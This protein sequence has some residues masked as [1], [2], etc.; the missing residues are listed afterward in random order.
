MK[1]ILPCPKCDQFFL[2]PASISPGVTLKCP[3]CGFHLAADSLFIDI[4][5]QAAYW[6][7]ADS[8]SIDDVVLAAAD[9]GLVKSSEDNLDGVVAEDTFSAIDEDH[10]FATSGLIFEEALSTESQPEESVGTI[11]IEVPPS[12]EWETQPSSLDGQEASTEVMTDNGESEF[13]A[14]EFGF[15]SQ[16][17]DD[18]TFVDGS[19]ALESSSLDSA[20]QE[21]KDGI[22]YSED[23]VLII[24]DGSVLIEETIPDE[25]DV[26]FQEDSLVKS[27]QLDDSPLTLAPLPSSSA[28]TSTKRINDPF[29]SI[30]KAPKKRPQES[31][32]K[33][34]GSVVGGGVA[35]VP[36]A[37]L[38]MWYVLGKDPL[39]AGPAVAQFVPW[40]VP[41][42]FSDASGMRARIAKSDARLDGRTPSLPSVQMNSNHDVA[43]KVDAESE[44]VEPQAS[45]P[46]SS[47][48][49]IS[50]TVAA[51]PA[52]AEP[53]LGKMVEPRLANDVAGP[54]EMPTGIPD[55]NIAPETQV[56]SLE[57]VSVA[58]LDPVS[59]PVKASPSSAEKT[60]SNVP[61]L[62]DALVV[63]DAANPKAAPK[64]EKGESAA[65]LNPPGIESELW[66]SI[67]QSNP[68][69][70]IAMLKAYLASD[71]KAEGHDR[72][73]K[74]ALNAIA[75]D[76]VKLHF[77]NSPSFKTWQ[78]AAVKAIA[79]I[80]KNSDLVKTLV[81]AKTSSAGSALSDEA[82]QSGFSFIALGSVVELE[83]ATQWLPNEKS[84]KLWNATRILVPK[85]ILT[86]GQL[87]GQYMLLGTARPSQQGGEEY[88]SD[89]TVVIA[90]PLF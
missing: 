20:E 45:K 28:A 31:P 70:S 3:G 84:K 68:A 49:L 66:D 15:L 53:A 56:K 79:P 61:A 18:E 78:Q 82:S 33:M 64:I 35:A 80:A 39:K 13:A 51:E 87:G 37:I 14:S 40:I 10:G 30:G 21:S 76:L 57:G 7:I 25:L 73:V 69:E 34:I 9:V 22:D 60:V 24:D 88:S 8:N 38:L 47:E 6:S 42:E 81:T 32:L 63:P 59:S 2:P 29:G 1:T 41:P 17:S 4:D 44:A 58:P 19:I 50:E 74:Q 71:T 75:S 23:D 16:P 83:G 43:G 46:N 72:K 54:S 77:E 26:M 90:L 62:N 86:S 48:P 27:P 52:A 89:F 55:E 36:I 12:N 5:S 65:K 67:E 11:A 85:S